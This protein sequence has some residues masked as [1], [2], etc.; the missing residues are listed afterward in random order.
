LGKRDIKKLDDAV[1]EPDLVYPAVR[2]K[3]ISRWRASPGIYVLIVQDPNTREGYPESR[4]KDEW[5][6]TYRYLQQ[7]E[8]PLRNR[9]AFIKY[10]EP[11][12][13][14][15]SQFNI[16]DYTFKPYKVIWKRMASD[17]VAAVVSTFATPFGDKVGVGTDTT[18]LIPFDDEAEAHCVCAL[19]N[20]SCVGAFIR[21]FSSAGRGFGAPSIINHIALPAY[22]STS[23]LHAKLSA[24]S[25]QAHRL[26]TQG[27]AYEKELRLVQQDIDRQ[28]ARLWG[29][30]DSELA[31]ISSF[32]GI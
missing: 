6:E 24:L 4:M 19:I 9:A 13:A 1:L 5:P 15:Y 11:S 7:F 29:L 16:S 31:Q 22:T 3:D 18:S 8:V 14:F 17:L 12:D 30:T 21:S 2:G 23:P 27:K 25:Q 28:A 26:A 20:S 32:R 10:Y